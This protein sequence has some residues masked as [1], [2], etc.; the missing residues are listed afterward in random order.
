MVLT[1]QSL[2]RIQWKQSTESIF[3]TKSTPILLHCI[4][5]RLIKFSIGNESEDSELDVDKDI[6]ETEVEEAESIMNSA[7]KR[8]PK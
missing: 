6:S 7:K 1:L 2:T 4:E 5:R 8:T 3:Q